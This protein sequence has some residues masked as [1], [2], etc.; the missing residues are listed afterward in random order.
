M[1]RPE[2][3]IRHERHVRQ[4]NRQQNYFDL[5]IVSSIKLRKINRHV[6]R[7]TDRHTDRHKQSICWSKTFEWYEQDGQGNKGTRRIM[8][9][10]NLLGNNE[11][12]RI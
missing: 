4:R 7:C 11:T 10:E 12:K 9:Q 3:V 6:D 1:L 5:C 8:K 2:V